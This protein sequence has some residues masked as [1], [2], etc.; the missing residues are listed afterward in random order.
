MWNWRVFASI[1]GGVVVGLLVG[2]LWV[3]GY[4][5]HEVSLNG[6]QDVLRDLERRVTLKANITSQDG[7]LGAVG[8]VLIVDEGKAKDGHL[9]FARRFIKARSRTP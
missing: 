3:K 9:V 2:A 5:F 1:V 6:Q 8:L 4:K 7:L